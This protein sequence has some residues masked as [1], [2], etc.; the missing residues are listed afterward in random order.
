[1]RQEQIT[2]EQFAAICE[3]IATQFPDWTLSK[4][5]ESYDYRHTLTH[6][7]GMQISLSTSKYDKQPRLNVTTWTWPKYTKQDRGQERT[8]TV[9]PSSL[10]N[11]KESGPSITCALNRPAEKLAA[12][13][14][15][16]FLP[17]YERVWQR[18]TERAS[19]YQTHENNS[20]SQWTAVCSALNL[21]PAR[22]HHY[23][24]TGSESRTVSIQNMNGSLRLEFYATQEQVLAVIAAMRNA[25]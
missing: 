16:R 15:R 18:C 5:G 7:S 4:S 11:P 9:T 24:D 22:D 1:M 8:E 2:L 12:E 17:E 6:A 10:W 19:E 20:A 14:R 25:Q 3:Q 23:V 13:I 21:N